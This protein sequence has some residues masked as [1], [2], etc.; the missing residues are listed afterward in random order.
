MGLFFFMGIINKLEIFDE[1]T[2]H[3]MQLYI[4]N[5]GRI[6]IQ[7]GDFEDHYYNGFITIDKDDAIAL[8]KELQKLIKQM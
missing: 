7:T 3:Q 1:T 2:S 6:Y 4:N 5:D 8:V